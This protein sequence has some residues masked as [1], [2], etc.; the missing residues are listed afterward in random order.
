MRDISWDYIAAFIDGEGYIGYIP[1]TQIHS[2]NGKE[3]S[4]IRCLISFGQKL[5]QSYIIDCIAKKLKDNNINCSISKQ[6]YKCRQ[7]RMR[8][9]RIADHRAILKLFSYIM[10]KLIVKQEIAKEMEDTILAKKWK[11]RNV[12]NI[13]WK[14]KKQVKEYRRKYYKVHKHG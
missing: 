7:C 1:Y 8:Y 10:P 12:L 11:P 9:I 14:D 3:Y 5:E 6:N 13:N 4:G 2:S